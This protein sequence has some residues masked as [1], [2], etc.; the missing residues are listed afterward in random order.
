MTTTDTDFVSI[1][2]ISQSILL[3]RGHR[4]ILD[5]DLATIYGVEPRVLNQAIKRNLDRFPSDFMFQ[6]SN[7]DIGALRSQSATLNTGGRGQHRK[8]TP[9]A[10][11]E[12]GT[13]QAA[14][15]VNSSRAVEMSIHVVRAFVQLRAVLTSNKELAEKLTQL[16]RLV[17]SHDTMIVDIMKTIRQLTNVPQTRAIGFVLPDEEER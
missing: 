10:F 7:A 17:D 5:R 11:T 4:V 15:C 16:E 13:I 12:H 9:Y 8:Y 3:L 14:N 1:E 2:R 6:L